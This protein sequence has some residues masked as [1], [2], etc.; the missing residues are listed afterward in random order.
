MMCKV[1]L[2]LA[3]GLAGAADP[4]VLDGPI[5]I[6]TTTMTAFDSSGL[7]SSV[8]G[9]SASDL[10]ESSGSDDSL[11]SSYSGSLNEGSSGSHSSGKMSGSLSSASGSDSTASGSSGFYLP[12]WLWIV[13]LGL[14]GL[15]LG[16]AAGLAGGKKAKKKK[17]KS[18]PK[19]AETEV[20]ELQPL[21]EVPALMPLAP[22]QYQ[23]QYITSTVAAPVTTAVAAPMTTAYAAPM[24]TSAYAP[25]I[26]T[27]TYAAQPV[28]GQQP[29]LG[30][31]V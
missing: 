8:S 18:A 5:S 17:K 24:T 15:C 4:V 1:V 22:I 26:G 10:T 19:P 16:A 2:A 21:M 31:V 7:G 20:V 27:Q 30:S 3:L 23:P 25:A 12:I 29:Y 13:V 11:A 9:S 14:L 6:V 28:Y